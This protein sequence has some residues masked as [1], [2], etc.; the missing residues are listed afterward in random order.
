MFLQTFFNIYWVAQHH[1]SRT[2]IPTDIAFG[3]ALRMICTLFCPTRMDG[4]GRNKVRCGKRLWKQD[5]CLITH[6]DNPGY[7]L[8]QKGRPAYTLQSRTAFCR[9]RWR[10]EF[11]DTSSNWPRWRVM[12]QGQ[13]IVIIDAGGGTIDVSTYK[14]VLDSGKTTFEEI[15]VAQCEFLDRLFI[16]HEHNF[17]M[18]RLF[19]GVRLRNDEGGGF[20]QRHVPRNC[21]TSHL[22]KRHQIYLKTH[23][24]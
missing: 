12:L 7:P 3:A 18:D 11:V 19:P 2:A 8:W 4:K 20:P 21:Y 17:C 13:G 16:R 14:R 15:S 23:R 9:K 6:R 22:L 10:F 5:W 24:I 1:I